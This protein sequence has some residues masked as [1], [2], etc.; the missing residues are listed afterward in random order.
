MNGARLPFL[1][2]AT[3]LLVGPFPW[4]M[5]FGVA[6][7]AVTLFGAAIVVTARVDF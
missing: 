6:L 1:D 4:T 2:H 7:V 5:V 3:F